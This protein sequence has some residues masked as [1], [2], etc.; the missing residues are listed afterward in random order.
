MMHRRSG[1]CGWKGGSLVLAASLMA[2]C[3]LAP[4]EPELR[5][6]L[7][8]SFS[9]SGSGPR[10]ER[11]WRA[12]EDS[13]L[14]ERIDQALGSNLDLQAT[15]QRLEEAHALGDQE[16]AGLFPSLELSGRAQEQDPEPL[17]SER[18]S[19]TLGAEYEL[20]LW[21][22]IRAGAEAQESRSQAVAADYHSAALSLAAEVART[23]YQI[24]EVDQR[25]ILL[26]E[27]LAT[28]KELLRLTERRLVNGQARRPDVLRQ[29]QQVETLRERRYALRAERGTLVHQ[30]AVFLGK[31]PQAGI[32]ADPTGL[33]ELPE[34]PD[35]GVPAQLVQRRPD[36]RSAFHELQ[37]ADRELAA[38]VSRRLPRLTLTAEGRTAGNGLA[39]LGDEWTLSLGGGLVAPLLDAGRR[40]AEAE[41]ARAVERRRLY[42]YGEAVLTAFQ[43]VEDALLQEKQQRRRV[44]SLRVQLD[45]AREAYQRLR[46]H[47]RHGMTDYIDVLTS[48]RDAQGLQRD[49]LAAKRELLEH[50]I[51]LYRAL[52]GGIEPAQRTSS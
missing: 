8:E 26:D 16:S 9:E 10:P 3:T 14:N 45:D 48:L 29:R 42:A 20:D 32:D 41:Q 46:K 39:T 52:A 5:V 21:G 47:Y 1:H 43:E 23:W 44:T 22:R 35:A 15:W 40:A 27:Q 37:A 36:V 28:S 34:M 38:A 13:G 33:P 11:W 25:L 2:G 18:L 30:L 19:A 4:E 50:R 12:F 31:P 24:A 17:G 6:D 7:D 49:L 51:A